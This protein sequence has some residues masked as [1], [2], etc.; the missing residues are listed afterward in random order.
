MKRS[1]TSAAQR[2]LAAPYQLLRNRPVKFDN[3]EVQFDAKEEKTRFYAEETLNLKLAHALSVHKSQGSEYL[4]VIVVVTKSHSY[5]LYRKLLYTAVTRGKLKIVVIGDP[6]AYRKAVN[7]NDGR[8]RWTLLG[9]HL[10][11]S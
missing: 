8:N 2:T 4:V 10:S 3:K 6:E 5:S 7:D 1:L 9:H 11:N